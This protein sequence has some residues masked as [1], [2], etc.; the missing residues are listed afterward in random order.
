MC[1][2]LSVNL[3]PLSFLPPVFVN[4]CASLRG[5]VRSAN[6]HQNGVEI[7][8]SSDLITLAIYIKEPDGQGATCL[9]FR[10]YV[11]RIFFMNKHN[12][13]EMSCITRDCPTDTFPAGASLEAA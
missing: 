13:D 7:Q 9:F 8:N 5:Q 3:S 12:G 4:S 1:L 2:K 6:Q 11:S 10:L